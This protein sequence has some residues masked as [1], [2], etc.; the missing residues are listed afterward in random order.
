MQQD[1]GVEGHA[2]IFSC[3]N[4][5][6]TTQCRTTINRRMLDPT[7]K[8]KKKKIPHVQQQR[9]S[10]S[11]MVGGAKS[12]LES[13]PIP[14]RD[15]RRAPTKPCTHQQTLQRLSHTCLWVF[16]CLLWRYRSAVACHRGQGFW[17][18]QT[19]VWHK[20]SW[21]RLPLTPQRAARIYTG[22]GKHT[23]ERHKQNL[24]GMR[25]QEKGAV[26]LQETDSDLPVSVQ[27]SPA[28]VWI[29]SGL[30]EG[31]GHWAWHCVHRTFWRRS[32]LYS[33][34]PPLPPPYST[35]NRKLY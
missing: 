21:R 12:H 31:R 24:V 27:E 17:V 16:E 20:P 35:I 13:N 23:L 28:E 18:Q 26:T 11:K 8:K 22:L 3:E 25:T 29:S 32:P 1:D 33:L 6:I 15:T 19:W 14:S 10:P 2:L 7:K 5:K 4:S 9:R 30:L 34:S